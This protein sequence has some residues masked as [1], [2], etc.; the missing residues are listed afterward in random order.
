MDDVC[1]H[2]GYSSI[3]SVRHPQLEEIECAVAVAKGDI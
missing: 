2:V 3:R 1:M